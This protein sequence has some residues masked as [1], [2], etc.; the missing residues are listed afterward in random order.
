MT[1]NK[2][3]MFLYLL[4]SNRYCIS[5]VP[6]WKTQAEIDACIK[7]N[8]PAVAVAVPEVWKNG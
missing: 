2:L 7:A 4:N 6:R 1:S 3:I 8:K 5:S